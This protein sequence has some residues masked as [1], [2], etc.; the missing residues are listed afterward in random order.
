MNAKILLMIAL[1]TSGSAI[2]EVPE[3]QT[4][5]TLSWDMIIDGNAGGVTA[6]PHVA[7][8]VEDPSDPD[9]PLTFPLKI[10]YDGTTE[11][12]LK[13]L[14]SYHDWQQFNESFARVVTHHFAIVGEVKYEK[15][16][17]GGYLEMWS[18]FASPAPG[19][20]EEA[21]FTRTLADS[22][23]MGRL[24]GTS[25][26]REFCLPF[27]ATGTKSKLARLEMNLHLTGPGTVHLRNMRLVQ[28]PDGP[29]PATSAPSLLTLDQV[30]VQIDQERISALRS[31]WFCLGIATTALT[32]LAGGGIIFISRR[33]NRRRHERELRRIAS[34]D[35]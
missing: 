2:A 31:I 3:G 35:S 6:P 13:L 5:K 1:L 9:N 22:G 21:Y 14:P 27:D 15:V 19:Y 16:T 11:L 30:S 32:L 10:T 18:H 17:P 29:L 25:D 8:E 33:W 24:D 23:P 7:I 28:Y 20:P 34:L 4:L 26:W 12:Q